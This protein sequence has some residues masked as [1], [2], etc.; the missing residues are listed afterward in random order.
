MSLGRT[1]RRHRKSGFTTIEMVIVLALFGIILV[2]LMG[3]HLVAITA[4]TAAETSSIAANLARARM[5]ELL[6][7]P[8]DTL[9]QQNGAEEQRQVPASGG[10]S[11][12]VH[13]SVVAPDP[14]RLDIT[15]T[16]TWQLAY[17]G[18]CA[19]GGSSSQCA[20]SSPV[21]YARTLQTRIQAPDQGQTQP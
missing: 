2:S 3:L 12:T 8:P 10:R 18:T 14:A 15:V 4:G 13:T 11:Y 5:E 6:S 19:G 1:S 7:L 9:K 20:G 16:V 17:G 21:T